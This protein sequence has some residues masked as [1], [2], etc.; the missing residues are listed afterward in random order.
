MA[1]WTEWLLVKT[2]YHC[3]ESQVRNN[4]VFTIRYNIVLIINN[5]NKCFFNLYLA[6]SAEYELYLLPCYYGST[7]CKCYV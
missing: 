7:W 5:D 4:I 3:A 6:P 2:Y 1:G